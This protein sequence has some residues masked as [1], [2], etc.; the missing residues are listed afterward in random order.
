MSVLTFSEL[1]CI[2][3]GDPEKQL[4]LWNAEEICKQRILQATDT[5]EHLGSLASLSTDDLE[6]GQAARDKLA[7][8]RELADRFQ[9]TSMGLVARKYIAYSG[10]MAFAGQYIAEHNNPLIAEHFELARRQ[11]SAD[12]GLLL[13]DILNPGQNSSR[14]AYEK[15]R[16]LAHEITCLKLVNFRI[17]NVFAIPTSLRRDRYTD[18]FRADIVL[19][20]LSREKDMVRYTDIKSNPLHWQP[21]QKHGPGMVTISSSSVLRNNSAEDD[22]WKHGQKS[23]PKTPTSWA[24]IEEETSVT[25]N[26]Y[27]VAKLMSI[28]NAVIEAAF[29]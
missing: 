13:A 21:E 6:K 23:V 27:R 28:R 25:L 18:E 5:L 16:G 29:A 24:L 1:E 3:T 19:V 26:P 17:D 12:A 4:L 2:K 9:L 22:F 14:R 10:M 7:R 8:A 11:A 20:D 15:A